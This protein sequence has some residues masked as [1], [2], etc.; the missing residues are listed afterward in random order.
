MSKDL[1]KEIREFGE[2]LRGVSAYGEVAEALREL[3]DDVIEPAL[4]DQNDE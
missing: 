1:M 4:M 2:M 3:V